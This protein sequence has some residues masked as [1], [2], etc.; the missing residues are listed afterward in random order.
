MKFLA[1]ENFPYSSVAKL[2]STGYEVTYI[3]EDHPGISDREVLQIGMDESRTILTFD[4]DYGELIFKKG[5]RPQSGVIYFRIFDF[6]P[7]EP[8]HLLIEFLKHNPD[9]NNFLTV[10]HKSAIRQRRIK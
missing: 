8:A 1:D 5:F 3:R 10:I 2:R 9:F 6:M 4:R 7:E